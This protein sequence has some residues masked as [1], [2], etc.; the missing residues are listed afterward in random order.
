MLVSQTYDIYSI[1]KLCEF[2][3]RTFLTKLYNNPLATISLI[4]KKYDNSD[5]SLYLTSMIVRG[6]GN[7]YNRTSVFLLGIIITILLFAFFNAG[8]VL[9]L[10][11]FIY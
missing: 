6:L 8:V 4:I 11:G 1:Q 2:G 10:L 9:F 3:P 5:I 7:T